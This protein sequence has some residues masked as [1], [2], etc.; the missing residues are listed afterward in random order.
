VFR[1]HPTDE[2]VRFTRE[3]RGWTETAVVD[4]WASDSSSGEAHREGDVVAVVTI[5]ILSQLLAQAGFIRE[6]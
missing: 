3:T 5:E 4:L 1:Y 2:I 6:P